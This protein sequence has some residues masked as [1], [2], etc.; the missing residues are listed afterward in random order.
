MI[1]LLNILLA[2]QLLFLAFWGRA[3]RRLRESTTFEVWCI[4]RSVSYHLAKFGCSRANGHVFGK[5]HEP[6]R[7]ERRGRGVLR[8]QSKRDRDAGRRQSMSTTT[9]SISCV[10]DSLVISKPSIHSQCLSLLLCSSCLRYTFYIIDT[11]NKA[12][13]RLTFCMKKYSGVSP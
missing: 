5:R 2:Q 3:L 7:A 11:L 12:L 10:Y 13:S 8:A 1:C 4:P 9:D 6:E